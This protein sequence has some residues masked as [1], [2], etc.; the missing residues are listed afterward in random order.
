VTQ[1]SQ[2]FFSLKI[3][4]RLFES[5]FREESLFHSIFNLF[6]ILRKALLTIE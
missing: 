4:L 5:Y 1:K 3:E 6:F 2:R